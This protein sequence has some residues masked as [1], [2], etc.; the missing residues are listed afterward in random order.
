MSFVIKGNNALGRTETSFLL[1]H[2]R[3]K[4]INVGVECLECTSINFCAFNGLKKNVY[5]FDVL[6]TVHL[7]IILVINQLNA[8][9]LVL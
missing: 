3:R 2:R 4:W 8:Q 7:S 6:L 5:C 1:E 9:I